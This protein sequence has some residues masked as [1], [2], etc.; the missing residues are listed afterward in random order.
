MI[1]KKCFYCLEVVVHDQECEAIK[2]L[3]HTS[4][5]NLK[6][7]RYQIYDKCYIPLIIYN[8]HKEIFDLV[9]T[10]DTRVPSLLFFSTH[11]EVG[12]KYK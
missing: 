5:G 10:I 1:P 2:T 7:T 3:R 12:K 9:N 6:G 11:V 8:R 4:L